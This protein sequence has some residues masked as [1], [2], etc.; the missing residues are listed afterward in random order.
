MKRISLGYSDFKRTVEDNYY[1]VDKTLF[2]KEVVEDGSAV[3]LLPR[4][5]RFGK[6]MNM[7]M[8]K[9]F[10]EKTEE[11]N[12]ELFKDLKIYSDK[13]IMK[14]QGQ[15]PVIFITFKDEKYSKWEFCETGLRKIIKDEF[16]KHRYILKSDI[17]DPFEK[18]EFIKIL[19]EKA[20]YV[21]YLRG[22]KILS[23]Y[24]YRFY[25]QKVVI[26]ID[27]YDVP[28]QSGYLNGYYDEIIE[29]MRN[30]L[31][32]GLKD[33][34]NLEKGI[35]T[36]ILTGILR[37]AKESIF[38]GL[39]NIN[40]CTILSSEYSE[41]FGFTEEE[42]E[43]TLKYYGIEANMEELTNWYNG[44]IFGDRVIYNPWSVL[45]Y[46]KRWKDGFK[47][48][49]TNT[50]SNDLVKTLVT[51]GGADLKGDLEELIKG[52]SIEKRINEDIVMGEIDKNTE[53]VWSFLLFSGYLKVVKK[54]IDM[55]EMYCNLSIPNME[56]NYLYRQIILGWFKESINNDKFNIMLKSLVTGDIKTFGKI[57]KDFVKNS[58]SYFDA[59]GSESEKVYHAFVLGMLLGLGDNYEVKSNR[60][61]GYGRYDVMVI[62]KD[63]SKIGIVIEFKKVDEDDE[64]DLEKAADSA[65]K[66]IRDKDYKSELIEK[67][68]KN[69]IELGIAFEGKKVLVKENV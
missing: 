55:G 7:S 30:F 66:Q 46:V 67:D 64:E 14:K 41:Y 65:L 47:P 48:Y 17:L 21:T 38:S 36:G 19:E 3:I 49:W 5:R 12:G 60:E 56:V 31:S 29:F 1:F 57:L 68:I 69:I 26:L 8:L 63:I 20:D 24:L 62:P 61:S 27:E 43:E 13:E 45:N 53:N 16:A 18:E 15:Y 59:A 4:P 44:Y 58:M 37:V 25:K 34:E 39:N 50:S 42:V 54:R 32:A 2:I 40:V 6:S 51:K 35:L 23:N 10:F 33:N 11:S 9:C 28:I 52:R 22:L